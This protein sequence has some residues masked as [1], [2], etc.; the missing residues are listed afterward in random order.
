MSDPRM[1]GLHGTRVQTRTAYFGNSQHSLHAIPVALALD[2]QTFT[3]GLE[4]QSIDQDSDR[5]YGQQP[6]AYLCLEPRT[7]EDS[8]VVD[9]FQSHRY[10]PTFKGLTAHYPYAITPTPCVVGLMMNDTF[11]HDPGSEFRRSPFVAG[12][13]SAIRFY[14]H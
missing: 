4:P 14:F 10:C 5:W 2:L 7:E 9:T 8:P 3:L 6:A 11:S 1:V 12:N 13:V